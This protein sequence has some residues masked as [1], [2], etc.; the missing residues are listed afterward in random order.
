MGRV[1]LSIMRRWVG[2]M[3]MSRSFGRVDARVC[4]LQEICQISV[5][6]AILMQ[7]CAMIESSNR[8]LRALRTASG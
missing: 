1:M 8:V 7:Q 3:F 4:V 5:K 2:G 6:E